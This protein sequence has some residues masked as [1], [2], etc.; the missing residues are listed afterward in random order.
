MVIF[1][2]RWAQ[3]AERGVEP[4]SVV[5]V[6]NARGRSAVTSANDS[7][8]DFIGMEGHSAKPDGSIISGSRAYRAAETPPEARY[9]PLILK[10]ER[11]TYLPVIQPTKFELV[12]NLKTAKALGLDVPPM[13]PARA[14]EV[15]E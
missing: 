9:L 4:P 3:V 2:L 6:F 1:E 10:G 12:V 11:P 7:C 15:I 8:P 5:D 13:L 14:D